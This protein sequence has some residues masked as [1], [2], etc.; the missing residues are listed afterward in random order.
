MD[1]IEETGE[2]AFQD[3]VKTIYLTPDEPLTYYSNKW[4]YHEMPQFEQWLKDAETQL[5]QHHAQGSHHLMFTFPENTELS[6]AF[7]D[8]LEKESY[9]LGLMEMYAI[10][11]EALKGEIPDTLKIEWVDGDN[12][13]DYLTIHRTFA[14]Q[15][16]EDY[17]DESE[18][19]IRKS[20]QD[21]QQVKRIVVYYQN[22]PV[23]S[24][25]AIET[26]QTLEIDS[27]GVIESMRRQGIGRTMQAFVAAHAEGKPIILVADGE[28]TAKDMYIKQGYTFISYRYQILKENV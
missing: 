5:Q 11:A 8:Y 6:L 28:D 10:E 9:E 27:F 2:I 20:F 25:D 15:F 4:V 24:L 19:T 23:G 18:R 14:L 1:L 26:E 21:E 13:D 12:L 22:Q 17:A 7:Q 3:H 16:G